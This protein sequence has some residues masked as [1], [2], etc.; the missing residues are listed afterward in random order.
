MAA[1]KDDAGMKL[2]QGTA[3]HAE[4]L[5]WRRLWDLLLAPDATPQADI[6]AGYDVGDEERVEAHVSGH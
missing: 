1:E 3:D 4:G 5:A 6:A 2:V